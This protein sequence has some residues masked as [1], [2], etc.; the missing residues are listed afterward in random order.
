MVIR[1]GCNRGFA[2]ELRHWSFAGGH[3]QWFCSEE[4][5]IQNSC[6]PG[7]SEELNGLLCEVVLD[8]TLHN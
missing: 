3:L 1:R 5:H 6:S 4:L 7:L 8:G 2:L